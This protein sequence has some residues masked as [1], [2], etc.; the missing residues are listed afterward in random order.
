MNIAPTT[1]LLHTLQQGRLFI[2]RRQGFAIGSEYEIGVL[3][4]GERNVGGFLI[5][6]RINHNLPQAKTRP[7]LFCIVIRAN[8]RGQLEQAFVDF[9]ATNPVDEFR[10]ETG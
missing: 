8:L 6:I 7:R 9:F 3:R 2:I 10:S 4:H 5:M 1:Y